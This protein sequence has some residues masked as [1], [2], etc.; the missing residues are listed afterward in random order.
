M[1]RTNKVKFPYYS[2]NIYHADVLG[3]VNLKQFIYAIKSPEPETERLIEDI[4]SA[5]KKGDKVLKRELK[6]K[7]YAFTPSVF[8]KVGVVRKY[9]NIMYW[10]G[11]MQLDF[12]GIDDLEEAKL[13][14]KTIFDNHPEIICAFLSPSGGVKCLM[15]TT[16]PRDVLHYKAL[17]RGMVTT[18]EEYSYLDHATN[19]AVLPLFLSMDRDILWREFEDCSVWAQED[20]VEEK[21]VALCSE[22]TNFIPSKFSDRQKQYFY[23]KVVRIATERISS[24]T[25]NGHPQV[26]S[27]S[28]I[29]GSRCAAGYMDIVDA[30]QL[31]KNNIQINAYLQKDVNAYIKTSMWAIRQ[32]FN[33]PK[34]F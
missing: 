15:R 23:D 16:T 17:H 12:D 29:I 28:L 34:Y 4:K 5:S 24:I 1:K 2:G 7:L 25:E 14:K 20:W 10:T 26:R 22:P 33:A 21:K 19:N 11:L 31:M 13:L 9:S 27:A 6:Q 30:E 3:I 32:G 18:F 8:I